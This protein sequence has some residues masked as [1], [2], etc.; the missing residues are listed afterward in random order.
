MFDVCG[1]EAGFG[2][3]FAGLRACVA[4]LSPRHGRDR[5]ERRCEQ[6]RGSQMMHASLL[7]VETVWHPRADAQEWRVVEGFVLSEITRYSA[8]RSYVRV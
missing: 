7:I 6:Q 3:V 4:R 1:A 2:G 8:Q 5:H